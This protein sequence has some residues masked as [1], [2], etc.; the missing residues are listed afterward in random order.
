MFVL[1]IP[2]QNKFVGVCKK[3]VENG[4][5][6]ISV[7]IIKKSECN[8]NKIKYENMLELP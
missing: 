3:C 6:A 5:K 8:G 2:E 7:E 1:R 4:S